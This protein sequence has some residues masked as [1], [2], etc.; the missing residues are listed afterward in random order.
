MK[1]MVGA[2]GFVWSTARSLLLTRCYGSFYFMGQLAE[3]LSL[4]NLG[5]QMLFYE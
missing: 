2:Q 4:Q 5:K 3:E 1:E